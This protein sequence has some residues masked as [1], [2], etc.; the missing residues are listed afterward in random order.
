VVAAVIRAA[1][2]I[3]ISRRFAPLEWP[4]LVAGDPEPRRGVERKAKRK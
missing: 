3:L 1:A 4:L 2:G